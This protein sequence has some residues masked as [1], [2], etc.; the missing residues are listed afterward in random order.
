[1]Q[2]CQ[3]CQKAE[4]CRVPADF[5]RFRRVYEHLQN[6]G[7]AA[8]LRERLE[9]FLHINH[10]VADGELDL[11]H[12]LVDEHMNDDLPPGTHVNQWGI[13][14]EGRERMIALRRATS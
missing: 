11:V 5:A 6:H 14:D 4:D 3:N 13:P 9:V 1:M 2:I 12:N 10:C 8:P 7:G